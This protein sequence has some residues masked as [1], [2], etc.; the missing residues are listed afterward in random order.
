MLG[1][2]SDTTPSLTRSTPDASPVDVTQ[3][4][5]GGNLLDH[6]T[7]GTNCRSGLLSNTKGGWNEIVP[8]TPRNYAG[9]FVMVECDS[10]KDFLV[11]LGIGPAGREEPVI[12]DM[13]LS[14]ASTNNPHL[15]FYVPLAVPAG[16]RLVTRCQSSGPLGQ[17]RIERL[18][19][20]PPHF[21]WPGGLASLTTVGANSADSGG[22][23]VDPGDVA[24]VRGP[25]VEFT[26]GL[27]TYTH[28]IVI[29]AGDRSGALPRGRWTIDIGIGEA[30]QEQIAV[31]DWLIRN[32]GDTTGLRGQGLLAIPVDI[33]PQTRIAARC[34]STQT[35][36][37]DRL[38]DVVL[39]A[40]G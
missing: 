18:Y 12:A 17:A 6:L 35:R 14:G 38:I 37:P 29:M 9:L 32:G 8:S 10:E 20:M 23:E 34:L 11:D 1:C 39:L 28:A 22:T 13:L 5:P 15:P 16:S 21:M 24:E 40:I 31:E 19:G 4:L 33:P 36:S 30:G 25:W 26:G 3:G 27:P 7:T 2:S